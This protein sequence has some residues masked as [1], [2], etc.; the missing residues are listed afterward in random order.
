MRNGFLGLG[1]P[2]RVCIVEGPAVTV[3]ADYR[4][5]CFWRWFS[6]EEYGVADA[7]NAELECTRAV[8]DEFEEAVK[9]VAAGE[10]VDIGGVEG[11]VL[12]EDCSNR[13]FGGMN[14]EACAVWVADVGATI[15][16][17]LL[18]FRAWLPFWW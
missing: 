3:F 14:W 10:D 12:V 9:G 7:L 2:L 18:G 16:L 8:L 6:D 13:W 1:F 17:E 4:V 15:G 5:D 11:W